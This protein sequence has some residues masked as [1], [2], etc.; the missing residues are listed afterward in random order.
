[1]IKTISIRLV[2]LAISVCFFLSNSA[3]A[4]FIYLLNDSPEGN[5]IYGY[6]VNESTGDLTPL[7]GFPVAT[8]GFGAENTSPE[9]LTI[10]R[11]NERL[12]VINKG[13]FTVSAF[14]IDTFTGSL[15]PLPFSPIELPSDFE[16][17]YQTIAVHPTGS[18]LIVSESTTATSASFNITAST[19]TAA[20]GSPF[21]TGTA[22]PLSSVFDRNGNFFYTGGNELS[23][24]GAFAGFS[25]N[26]A[27]G[28]LTPLV[29]SPFNSGANNDLGYTTDAQGRL[30]MAN[31]IGGKVKAST[32]TSGIPTVTGNPFNS[33]LTLASD[34]A[35]HPNGN[36]YVVADRT[37]NQVG[38]YQINGTGAKTTMTSV[39]GSPFASEGNGTNALVFNYSGTLLFAHNSESR[40]ITTYYVN[41]T[42]GMLINVNV[43]A[44]DSNGFTGNLSGIDYIQ[45]A[46]RVALGTISGRVFT[47]KKPIPNAIV[48]L[49]DQDGTLKIARTNMFGYFRFED[50]EVGETY[51]VNVYSKN[52]QFAPQII[53]FSENIINLEFTPFGLRR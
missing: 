44:T 53:N 33:G 43:Q 46:A 16:E 34:G 52:Y 22:Y 18:P 25:V 35:L 27:T 31:A 50:I 29:G 20:E 21:S 49:S 24:P 36:F 5:T 39:V 48:H 26:F 12:Y 10:D 40:N 1:M 15:S 28:V 47:A 7:N 9:L 4:G 3:D 38:S 19:A 13:S 37:G 2:L 11:T 14:S 41:S 51:I 8:G 45:D 42:N 32:S 23:N 30:F 17:N 6:S